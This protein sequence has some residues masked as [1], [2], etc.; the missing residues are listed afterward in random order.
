MI[1][2]HLQ[3]TK[4]SYAIAHGESKHPVSFMAD[5]QCEDLAFP[6]LFPKGKYGS[7]VNQE[8]KLSPIKYSNATQDFYIK[9]VDLLPILSISSLLSSS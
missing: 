2:Y 1:R 8:I 3:E 7:S 9:V 6:V 5:K 4:S